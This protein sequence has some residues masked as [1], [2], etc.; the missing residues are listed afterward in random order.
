MRILLVT[1]VLI[2]QES[3]ADR[4]NKLLAEKKYP[5]AIAAFTKIIERDPKAAWARVSIGFAW[6]EL[7]EFDKAAKAFDDAAAIDP[8]N[9][10]LPFNRGRMLAM[11]GLMVE[12]RREFAASIEKH[13]EVFPHW[14][15]YWMGVTLIAV[16]PAK[17]LEWFEQARE[18]NPAEVEGLVHYWRN[19]GLCHFNQ[20][21]WEA[22]A[23]LYDK[24]LAAFRDDPWL[25][26]MRALCHLRTGEV[27]KARE[28]GRKAE[29]TLSTKID[30]VTE[31]H[32]PFRGA[33]KVVQANDGDETHWG[34][35]A[36]YALDFA[37]VEKGELSK[38]EPRRLEDYFSW[39]AEVLAAAD[40]VV[41]VAVDKYDDHLFQPGGDPGEGNHVLIE[42]APKEFSA[43]YHL[44]RGSV[45]VKPGQKVKRGDV[46]GRCGSS[47]YSRAPHVHYV[48]CTDA[49]EW[50]CR[51]SKFTG[52][53]VD[54]PKLGD[55]VE[56]K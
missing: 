28:L 20:G 27:A 18:K 26:H 25:L 44:K 33:W 56:P 31:F 12:A 36:K 16:D 53:N 47:G 15:R 1:L 39:D 40:G 48:I 30:H 32:P 17:A 19:V 35:T 7:R 21:K 41:A 37:L 45:A 8:S 9:A 43:V 49:R 14:V 11:R 42:H 6:T 34:L 52:A 5:E 46:I 4:A 10:Y 13:A 22:A 29:A 24:G 38:S 51:P 2:G 23:R 55:V 3:D 50:I 54:V